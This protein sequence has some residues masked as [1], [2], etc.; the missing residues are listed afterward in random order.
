MFASTP[1]KKSSWFPWHRDKSEEPA[2]AEPA[3]ETSPAASGGLARKPASPRGRDRHFPPPQ[4]VTDPA[5]VAAV[6]GSAPVSPETPPKNRKSLFKSLPKPSSWLPFGH[7]DAEKSAE[8][9]RPPLADHDAA[10]PRGTTPD[11]PW[12]TRTSCRQ[13]IVP[14]AWEECSLPPA[15]PPSPAAAETL[16]SSTRSEPA[17]RTQHATTDVNSP[18]T[19]PGNGS[20][21]LATKG[22]VATPSLVRPRAGRR[23]IRPLCRRK[24]PLRRSP[25]PAERR[26]QR[27]GRTR[28]TR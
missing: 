6:K 12:T 4:P 9:D 16:Q 3:P 26:G 10:A 23:P 8:S 27:A 2:V 21:P 14:V 22:T 28:P 24:N 1:K 7:R 13:N 19:Q 18:P 5:A 20:E 17:W 15:D 25:S 11:A